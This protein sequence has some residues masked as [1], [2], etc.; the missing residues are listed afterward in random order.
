MEFYQSFGLTFDYHRHGKGVM[1]YSCEMNNGIVFEIYPLLKSQ[2]IPDISTRLGFKVQSLDVIIQK[3]ES[4][5]IKIVQSPK[6]TKWGKRAV[7]KDLDGRKV[8]LIE[9]A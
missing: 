9:T 5:N 1:H 6:M 4:L 7:V 8:E 3:L 2:T